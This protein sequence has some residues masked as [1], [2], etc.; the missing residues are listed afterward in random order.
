MASGGGGRSLALIE[1]HPP[2][3][4]WLENFLQLS[5]AVHD[6]HIDSATESRKGFTA[7]LPTPQP[8]T[9]APSSTCQP[10]LEC[11][12]IQTVHSIHRQSHM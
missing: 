3:S 12:A 1:E 11:N 8:R 5:T 7:Q 2:L 9:A 4:A 6:C 10:V